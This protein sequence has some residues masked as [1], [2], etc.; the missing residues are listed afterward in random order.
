MGRIY[1]EYTQF[2]KGKTWH[3]R[4][5]FHTFVQFPFGI[6]RGVF[7]HFICQ[8]KWCDYCLLKTFSDY[9]VINA[10]ESKPVKWKRRIWLL[11]LLHF[12]C[13]VLWCLSICAHCSR[14]VSVAKA[15]HTD[16]EQLRGVGLIQ[17]SI[18]G[19]GAPLQRNP[20]RNL[21]SGSH[22]THSWGQRETNVSVL[23]SCLLLLLGLVWL[24]PVLHSSGPLA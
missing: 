13:Y 3:E 9:E 6:E 14:F 23:P 4:K 21:N 16:Q 18:R 15:K 12:D 20:D 17:F 8:W 1:V 22:H 19:L 7:S 5:L 24:S 10:C 2:I 11:W